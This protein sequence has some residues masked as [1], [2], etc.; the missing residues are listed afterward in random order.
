MA[1]VYYNLLHDKTIKL[2]NRDDGRLQHTF[3]HDTA[4]LNFD[5]CH[6]TLAVAACDGTYIWSLKDQ[7]KIK[8]IGLGH[9]VMD[10]QLQGRSI[11]AVCYY[12]EV[13]AIKME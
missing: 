11:I 3:Q 13:Y 8:K 9:W 6:N 12:G 4:C 5:I 10:V 2:W 7:R 1:Y